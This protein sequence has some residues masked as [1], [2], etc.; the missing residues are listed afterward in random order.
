[1]S[2]ACTIISLAAGAQERAADGLRL[3]ERPEVGRLDVVADRCG[4]RALPSVSENGQ[5]Q[6]E[7]RNQ[8]RNALVAAVIDVSM[9]DMVFSLLR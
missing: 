7:H 1:L 8:Q 6:R 9:A 4:L 2:A 5:H 3:V